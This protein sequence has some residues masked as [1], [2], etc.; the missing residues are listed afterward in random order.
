MSCSSD[1]LLSMQDE[2]VASHTHAR[3]GGRH[4]SGDATGLGPVSAVRAI[5]AVELPEL[6]E[7]TDHSVP[8][9]ADAV[10]DLAAQ[11]DRARADGRRVGLDEGRRRA[12]EEIRRTVATIAAVVDAIERAAAE[13]QREIEERIIVLATAIAGHL[14]EREILTAPD[15][16]ASIVRRAVSAF[17]VDEPL[18]VHMNPSDLALLSASDG[19]GSPCS[20]LTSGQA[21]RWIADPSLLPG[22]CFVESPERVVDARLSRTLERICRALADD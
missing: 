19:E 9:R 20:R 2:I 8:H 10:S 7:A 3:A 18:T 14:V 6:R 4:A 15:V 22:G 12:Q 17:P 5:E 21:V 16:V 11:L 13:K 1:T